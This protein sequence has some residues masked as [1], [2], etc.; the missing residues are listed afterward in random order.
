[1]LKS[2]VNSAIRNREQATGPDIGRDMP[3]TH[4]MNEINNNNK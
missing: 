4:L 2:L 3:I 1:M